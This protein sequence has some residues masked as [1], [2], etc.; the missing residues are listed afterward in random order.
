MESWG[1]HFKQSAAVSLLF[2]VWPKTQNFY[3][4]PELICLIIFVTSFGLATV[5]GTPTC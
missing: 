2:P 4:Y 3:I 5:P 1:K